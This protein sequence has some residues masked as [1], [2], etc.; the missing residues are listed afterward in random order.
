MLIFRGGNW[1]GHKWWAA[2]TALV[3]VAAI[4]WS[5]EAWFRTGEWIGG[6]SLPGWIL[7]IVSGIIIHF[8]CLLGV[9]KLPRLRAVR[10]G[11]TQTWMRA[12]IWLGLLC[13]PL[14]LLHG[15]FRF[16]NLRLS[17][18]LMMLFLIVIVSG[19]VGLWL[20]Q[21]IP[22]L[23][24]EYVPGETIHSQINRVLETMR[25]E[26]AVLVEST[27]G[28]GDQE[29][30]RVETVDDPG[31]ARVWAVG[32]GAGAQPF[33][34]RAGQAGAPAPPIPGS[35]RL[36]TFYQ[37]RIVP[38]FETKHV[39]RVSLGSRVRSA[40]LFQE[41]KERV[42]HDAHNVI[43]RLEALCERRRQLALQAR[44]H[45]W[46]HA[47]LCIHAPISFALLVLLWF[48]IYYSWRYV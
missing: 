31:Q 1:S 44:L 37:E 29:A 18:V 35:D 20:Q 24:L 25:E 27:R 2:L 11:R 8:E 9:R 6:S 42:H 41:L 16:A 26:A 47:W 33:R 39:S 14:V 5:V 46:L 10:I 40:P 30:S 13:V 7:G 3:A 22:R 12:H 17:G 36:V 45:F 38:L 15:G 28:P 32:P 4:A 21:V 43:D 34:K 48:H 19:L 23:M